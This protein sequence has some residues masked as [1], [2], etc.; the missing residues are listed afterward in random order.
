MPYAGETEK[1][2]REKDTDNLLACIL[3]P[4]VATNTV[5]ADGLLIWRCFVVW[6]RKLR[7]AVLPSILLLAGAACGYALTYFTA[8]AYLIRLHLPLSATTPPEGWVEAGKWSMYMRTVF[9][10]T[11]L[12]TN[13]LVTILIAGRIL[14]LNRGL[15]DILG[16]KH[17]KTYSRIALILIESGAINSACLL[18]GLIM[19]GPFNTHIIQGA[20][21]SEFQVSTFVV[22]PSTIANIFPTLLVL[23]V[24]LGKTTQPTSTISYNGALDTH[25]TF[26]SIVFS[27]SQRHAAAD[28]VRSGHTEM[29]DVQGEIIVRK[30]ADTVTRG[31]PEGRAS[32]EFNTL[33]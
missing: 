1:Q 9:F 8:Q 15:G 26:P 5:I 18:L 29:S 17:A 30:A 28:Q 11:S 10:S 3:A 4:I 2:L 25:V 14:W 31:V 6:E 33:H 21:G 32:A 24:A 12:A 27:H 20:S 13:V 7:V 23:L 16:Q 22:F 19:D